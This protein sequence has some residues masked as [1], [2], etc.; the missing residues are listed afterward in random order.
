MATLTGY[1]RD[2]D[3]LYI[4]KDPEAT[5]IYTFDYS[6]W[7]GSGEQITTS[8]WTIDAI[9]GDADALVVSSSTIHNNSKSVLL[10]LTGGTAG[11]IY[12]LRNTII[13]DDSQTERKFFRVVCGQRSF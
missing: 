2:A 5:L 11:N 8:N 3:G 9:S 12:T 1:K 13:T 7:L 6:N 4:D 10:T